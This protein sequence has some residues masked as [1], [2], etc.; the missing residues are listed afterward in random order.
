[1][2]EV[3]QQICPVPSEQKRKMAKGCMNA[4]GFAISTRTTEEYRVIIVFLLC[5]NEIQ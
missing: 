2:L 5:F 1:M 3:G 4:H